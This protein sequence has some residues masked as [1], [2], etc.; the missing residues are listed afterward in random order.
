[1]HEVKCIL[2]L[3]VFVTDLQNTTKKKGGNV[4]ALEV[5]YQ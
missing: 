4:N 2:A 3:S 1:M 5:I